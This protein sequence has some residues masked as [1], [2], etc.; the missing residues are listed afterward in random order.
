MNPH[1]NYGNGPVLSNVRIVMV[2]YGAGTY[3]GNIAGTT[4]PTMASW[5]AQV[6]NSV[7]MDWLRE[8]NTDLPGGTNQNIGRGSFVG[9]Y[10]IT[11]AAARNGTTISEQNVQRTNSPR[12]W[13]REDCP[14]PTPTQST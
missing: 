6:V 10:Q 9:T 7:Y 2:R 11:P 5:Y 13:T 8:Y 4:A 1:L 3:L 14:P 12:N